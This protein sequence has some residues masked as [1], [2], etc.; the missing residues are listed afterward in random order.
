MCIKNVFYVNKLCQKKKK[1]NPQN[2][3]NNEKRP[4][5]RVC[6]LYIIYVDTVHHIDT[7]KYMDVY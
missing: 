4:F 6:V 7:V 1:K 2:I 3:K 5:D